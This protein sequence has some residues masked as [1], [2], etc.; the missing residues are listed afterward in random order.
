MIVQV[1][2]LGTAAARNENSRLQRRSKVLCFGPS[3]PQRGVAPTMR[4]RARRSSVNSA[5][6]PA[7]SP[8]M[9]VNCPSEPFTIYHLPFTIYHLPFTAPLRRF[10]IHD[11]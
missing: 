10:T 8:R 4:F 1:L 7:L 2:R 11:S 5:F 9:G 3:L 6:E